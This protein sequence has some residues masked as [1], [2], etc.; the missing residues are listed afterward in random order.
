MK[1]IRK[2]LV[3]LSLFAL[4]YVLVSAAT[5][6]SAVL[7]DETTTTTEPTTTTTE[8]T[9]TTTTSTSTTTSSTTT[10]ST[11]TTIPPDTTAPT[12]GSVSPTSVF[13]LKSVTFAATVFDNVAVAG[14]NMSIDGSAY[15]AAVSNG[16]ASV[17]LA[18]GLAKGSYSVYFRCWDAAGNLGTGAAVTVKSEVPQLSAAITLDK[19]TYYPTDSFNPRV[20]VTDPTGKIV[21]D[22][23]VTGWLTSTSKPGN[24]SLSFFYSTLCD[25]YKAWYYFSESTLPGDYTLTVTAKAAAYESAVAAEKFSVFK[26]AL[27]MKM[28]V[29]KAEYYPGDSVKLTI[30]F[31]DNIGNPVDPSS[32]SGEMRRADTGELVSLVYPWM[33]SE[34]VYYYTYYLSTSD[35]D[36]SYKFSISAK[37]KEQEAADSVTVAVTRRGVNADLVL[38]KNVLM[39]GDTLHGKIKVFDKSG[40]AVSSAWVSVELK[41]GQGNLYKYLTAE[42]KEGFYEIEA[43]K[44]SEWV[45]VGKYTLYATIKIKEGE[46]ITVTKTLEIQKEKLNVQVFFDQSSYSPGGRVYIKVLVTY[47]NGSVVGN[48]YIGGEIFPLGNWSDAGVASPATGGIAS[49]VGRIVEAA[50][51]L[52][53]RATEPVPATETK[54]PAVVTSIGSEPTICRIYVHPEGPLYYK[55]VWVQ[56]YYI[57]D[58]SIPSWCPTGT[59]ALKLTVSVPGYAETVVEKEFNVALAKLLLETGFKIDSNPSAVNLYIYAEVKDDRGGLVPYANIR[60]YLHPL[61]SVGCVKRVTLSYDDFTRRYTTS[62]YLQ[63][64]ECPVGV[65]MLEITA[66]Q[67]SYDT[68]KVEQSIPINY[69]EDYRYSVVVPPVVGAESP[70]CEE[71]SC[72]PGCYQ[73]ICSTAKP[74][75]QCFEE[76]MDK[77]CLRDCKNKATATEESASKGTAAAFDLDSCIAA[78]TKKIACLGSEVASASNEEMMRKLEEIHKE[79]G[80]TKGAAQTIID[81]LSGLINALKSLFGGAQFAQSSTAATTTTATAGNLTGG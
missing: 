2:A 35:V 50:K 46:S 30:K 52:A 20:K 75:E 62:A 63:K 19:K 66:S 41:D 14:C 54:V 55:G 47:P 1:T 17:T 3:L 74:A 4:S 31:T 48:A 28:S 5:L 38:E 34:G 76:V 43:W 80:E 7:A 39:P 21:T 27:G 77:D 53:G 57:D 36:R 69:T 32:I 18:S 68:A 51:T 6:P 58:S 11:T 16:V 81:M 12:V 8:P 45:T 65:Y 13:Q 25:C 40:N 56:K 26:P 64:Y 59:Y 49:I 29:D 73:K 67:A 33:S 71:V 23:T 42:Y 37:W 15:Q 72:G 9:T 61:E 79:V 60:G 22:A 70:V 24:T 78:C 10:T 44:A